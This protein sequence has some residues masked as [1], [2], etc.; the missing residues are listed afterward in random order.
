M[1]AQTLGLPPPCEACAQATPAVA[2]QSISQAGAVRQSSRPQLMSSAAPQQG[3]ARVSRAA[4]TTATPAKNP[5]QLKVR[6]VGLGPVTAAAATRLPA[7]AADPT[8]TPA[9]IPFARAAFPPPGSY[10]LISGITD[11]SH[12]I[13]LVGQSLGNRANVFSKIGDS[14]TANDVFLTPVGWGEYDLHQFTSLAP[15]ITYFSQANARTA[16]SFANT[17]L[18]AKV[19]WA[20]SRVIDPGAVF[21]PAVCNPNENPLE[22][23]YRVVKPSIALIMVGTNDVRYTPPAQYEAELR[24]IIQTSIDRGVIPVVSTIPPV[25]HDWAVGRVEV[26]NGIIVSLAREYDIPLWD[27]WSALQGL[28]DDGLSSDG[29]HP[30]VYVGH[31]ADFSQ[32]YLQAG[33]TVRNLLALQAL[34]AVWKAALH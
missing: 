19:G 10:P 14:M 5:G 7:P 11:H 34:D 18:A 8:S 20:A 17:S 12:Q 21:E 31:A 4:L 27:Y 23:E 25:H 9:A 32:D 6:P 26:I 22:C 33:Y 3:I 1:P 13:F 16:N 24:L 29:L 28:P 15:V 2:S 30:S